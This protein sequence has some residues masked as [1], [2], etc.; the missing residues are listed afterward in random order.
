[1]IL[2]NFKYGMMIFEDDN[3]AS[4]TIKIPDISVNIDKIKVMNDK[5]DRGVISP[6]EVKD[7]SL[8]ALDFAWDNTTVLDFYKP[9]ESSNNIKIKHSLGT[10]P[11]FRTNRL[12]GGS[13]DTTV[14][15]KRVND[16][17]SRISYIGGS[18]LT[19]SMV[20]PNDYVKF[21]K[22]DARIS[23]PFNVLNQGKEFL[24]QNKGVDFIDIIDNGD[25]IEEDSVTLGADFNQ[26][27]KVVS[28]GSI[29]K[30]DIIKISNLSNL[31]SQNGE[32]EIVDVSDDCLEIT[33]PFGIEGSVIYNESN[34]VVYK[35]LIGF[36]NLRSNG[37]LLLKFNNQQEWVP[38]NMI[39]DVGVFIG[40]INAYKIQIKND[41]Y[42]TITYSVQTME[43]I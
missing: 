28:Q 42:N 10:S 36:V 15:I 1:M 27:I 40:S 19:L 17:I 13:S 37:R 20:Q 4:P 38:L 32:F 34:F 31:P 26:V 30:G 11:S 25:S 16:Y 5:S 22:T 7:I 41:G 29:K 9:L 23:S 18:A 24:V 39:K 14:S 6:N 21:F 43:I 8:T 33:N 3:S 2:M 35:Y 12:I